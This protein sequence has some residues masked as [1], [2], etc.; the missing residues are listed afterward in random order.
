MAGACTGILLWLFDHLGTAAWLFWL[1]LVLGSAG[2][3]LLLFHSVLR[4]PRSPSL[5]FSLFVSTSSLSLSA[6][7]LLKDR[8]PSLSFGIEALACV[9]P[10]AFFVFFFLFLC[11][12][13]ASLAVK[14]I[15]SRSS[16][17]LLSCLCC[18]PRVGGGA[19]REHRGAD[20]AL[21]MPAG[22][23]EPG[24]ATGESPQKH[25]ARER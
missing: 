22:G 20:E 11:F 13:V 16:C 23:E 19:S 2:G 21:G 10:T 15:S 8:H 7:M 14:Q 18:D 12:F 3:A 17:P 6:V 1:E 25:C 4:W 24:A 5:S 9:A